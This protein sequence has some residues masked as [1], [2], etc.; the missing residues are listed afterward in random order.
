MPPSPT[1]TPQRSLPQPATAY[2][3]F[4]MLMQSRK[5][6][7]GAG[8]R[9]GFQNQE[10][11]KEV[12]G[13]GNTI[14]YS[15]RIYDSR[16]CRFLSVDPLA[17]SY[18]HNSTYAFSENR[19]IDGIE[20]EGL[21]WQ[22]VNSNG[23][24]VSP[25]SNEIASYVWV[26]FIE[27]WR[28]ENPS[29]GACGPPKPVLDRMAPPGTVSEA[30]INF[31]VNGS[32]KY[33]YYG[34]SQEGKPIAYSGNRAPWLNL[35]RKEYGVTEEPGSQH[36]ERIMEYHRSTLFPPTNDDNTTGMWCASFCNFVLQS[37][38][39]ESGMSSWSLYWAY[40]FKKNKMTQTQNAVY[41]SV[42]IFKWNSKE[43]HAGFVVGM[44]DKG[45]LYILGGNQGGKVCISHYSKEKVDKVIGYYLPQSYTLSPM[46]RKGNLSG[47]SKEDKPLYNS[48]TTVK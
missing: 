28:F 21:E 38:G 41:G 35:A 9:W 1:R 39:F 37:S 33:T 30:Q 4:G 22:P 40:E 8:Y 12:V 19:V 3:P 31:Q 14:S 26:G 5:Y 25:N 48:T 47:L 46:D 11:D 32:E 34:V 45:G 17:H 6:T 20:L 7:G 27:T 13:S 43:G 42:A 18:P 23:N 10:D 29:N 2:H 15:F 24:V 16:T 44:D 36:N